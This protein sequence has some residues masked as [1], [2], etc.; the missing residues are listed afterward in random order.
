MNQNNEPN[1][2]PVVLQVDD[3]TGGYDRQAILKNLS[4]SIRAGEIFFIAGPSGCGKSTLLRYLIG[5]RSPSKGRIEVLNHDLRKM[6]PSEEPKFY[7][8]IGVLFQGGAL[9]SSMTLLE[10]VALPLREHRQYPPGLVQ[11]I[12][13]LR[14]DQVGLSG[15]EDYFPREISG[16]MRKRAAL[17]RALALDPKILFLDEPSAGL[18]PLTS[19]K[20]DKLIKQVRDQ[21]GTTI[22]VVSHELNSIQALAD[23]IL[24][25]DPKTRSMA[26]LGSLSELLGDADNRLAQ[27]F[28]GSAED[29]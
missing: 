25:L 9:W 11:E 15:Y 19:R 29:E 13:L 14:L 10:N 22:V 4:F 8:S 20:M 28:F 17:A 1:N 24:L 21:F 18:D 16:G 3:L 23:R 2:R 6:T 12:A 5:L 7:Q 27:K 26:G